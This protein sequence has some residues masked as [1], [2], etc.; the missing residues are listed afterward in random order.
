MHLN[1][2]LWIGLPLLGILV[3]VLAQTWLPVQI[4][5]AVL[6]V[7]LIVALVVIFVLRFKKTFQD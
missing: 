5:G 4:P 3:F 2:A 7:A 1:H 6:V